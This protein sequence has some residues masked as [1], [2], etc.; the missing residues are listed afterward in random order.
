MILNIRV[1]P[2]ASRN[3]IKKENNSLKVYLT[4]LPQGGQANKQ[5]I[6]VLAEYLKVKKYQIK[7]TRGKTSGNKTVQIDEL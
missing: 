7:I 2:K 6:S 1:I 4:Q 3:L 5:L